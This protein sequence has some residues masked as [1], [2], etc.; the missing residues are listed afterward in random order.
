MIGGVTQT[1]STTVIMLELTG[2]LTHALPVILA[3]TLSIAVSRTFSLNI[4]S[5]IAK[6]KDFPF[7]DEL[8]YWKYHLLTKSIMRTH[9]IYLT[10]RMR[11]EDINHILE[12]APHSSFP[13]VK[14]QEDMSFL[15]EVQRKYLDKIVNRYGEKHKHHE[16]PQYALPWYFK[17]YTKVAQSPR[18]SDFLGLFTTDQQKEEDQHIEDQLNQTNEDADH[19]I[20]IAY[21]DSPV[22]LHSATKLYHVHL[23]FITLNAGRLFV[24]EEG[25][26][27]GIVSRS[28]LREALKI[29]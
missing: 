15:G 9:F 20:K 29:W 16:K 14:S 17:L 5:S 25:K 12:N 1:Y 19:K 13:V 4:F 2:Q 21:D 8:K 28:A 23:H 11:V 26:I 10:E 7:L 22:L 6:A 27:T 24:V 18:M 3:V